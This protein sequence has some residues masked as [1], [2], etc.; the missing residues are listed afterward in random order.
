M[1]ERL[2]QTFLTEKS[3]CMNEKQSAGQY[4]ES[5][6]GEKETHFTELRKAASLF[7]VGL[8]A[9]KAVAVNHHSKALQDAEEQYV[10]RMAEAALYDWCRQVASEAVNFLAEKTVNLQEFM[11][12]VEGLSQ[13]FLDMKE[14]L[15]KPGQNVLFIQVYDEQEDWPKF[16]KLDEQPVQ[17]AAE[18]KLLMGSK[19]LHD[20]Y[21]EWREQG[22]DHLSKLLKR[23]A[24]KR[25]GDDFAAHPR[26]IDLMQ[27]KLMQGEQ[28]LKMRAQ[29][30]V[31]AALSRA[32]VKTGFGQ[33]A[34]TKRGAFL[35][36]VSDAAERRKVFV[37]AV[38]DS[39]QGYGYATQNI[40]VQDTHNKGEVYLYT[41]NYAFP[42]PVMP[43]VGS[44]CHDTYYSFYRDLRR[45]QVG[46]RNYYRIPVH[47]DRRWEGKFE[48]LTWMSDEEA[49]N[50]KEALEIMLFGAVLGVTYRKKVKDIQGLVEFGYRRKEMLRTVDKSWGNRKETLDAL[51]N[52]GEL[53]RRFREA[54]IKREGDLD[55]GKLRAYAHALVFTSTLPAF[56]EGTVEKALILKRFETLLPALQKKDIV[57]K[58][59]PVGKDQTELWDW[60]RREAADLLVWP[61]DSELP[62]LAGMEPFVYQAGA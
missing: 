42:L 11:R 5:W 18:A 45:K 29:M 6:R 16:Y 31:A 57:L 13:P 43:L 23:F 27:H 49:V 9:G 2:Q 8:M 60:T 61:D 25:F 17:V 46:T 24:E 59:E 26:Q 22:R 55:A 37:Q 21:S 33:A 54:V 62:V 32:Q 28:N 50:H 19:T 48:D 44:I 12:D 14:S 1:T 38:M 3:E 41:V 7:V 34:Q 53:R 56:G 39:L 35:G 36:I 52:D 10:I 4:A 15:L 58:D 40:N 20:I 47:A 30:L 51:K